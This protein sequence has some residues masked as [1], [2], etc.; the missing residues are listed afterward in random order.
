VSYQ[1]TR[2]LESVTSVVFE[3]V[4]EAYG[5]PASDAFFADDLAV[6]VAGASARN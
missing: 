2:S 1:R 6:N 3:R 5:T 4:L